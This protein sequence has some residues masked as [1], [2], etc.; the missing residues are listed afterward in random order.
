MAARGH[1]TAV[2]ACDGSQIAGRLVATGAAPAGLDAFE[3]RK[4]QHEDA[5]VA[6]I[7]RARAAGEPYDLI[8]DE[9]GSFWQRRAGLPLVLA[10]DVYRFSY[11]QN[12]FEREIWPRLEGE[13]VRRVASPPFGEKV[14]LLLRARAL[15][16]TSSV[17][18]TSSLVAMEAMACGTP[19]VAF[20]LGALPEVVADG[21]TGFLVNTPEEMASAL[22][23]VGEIDPNTCRAYVAKNFTAKRMAD[24]YEAMYARVLAAAAKTG[25][26][27][28]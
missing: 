11:H 14:T 17:E 3:Y 16:V 15:L 19:V 9:G 25:T 2:G 13:S 24:D 1:V 12:Y 23:R 18:E 27:A 21:V 8:H 22:A 5:V 7:E 6:E 4:T 28:A 26:T 20:G 10:G